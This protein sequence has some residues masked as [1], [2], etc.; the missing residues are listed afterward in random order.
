ML[1]IFT[2][3]FK[4]KKTLHN[5][6]NTRTLSHTH[7]RAHARERRAKKKNFLVAQIKFISRVTNKTQEIIFPFPVQEEE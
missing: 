3:F 4:E 1:P 5:K 7:S 2:N 6:K